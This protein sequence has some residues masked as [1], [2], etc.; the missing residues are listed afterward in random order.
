MILELSK[1]GPDGGVKTVTQGCLRT[2]DTTVLLSSSLRL[3]R[4]TSR[5]NSS[6][7]GK[8]YKVSEQLL[9]I[10][11]TVSTASIYTYAK[12]GQQRSS[13]QRMSIRQVW[14]A[15]SETRWRTGL[16]RRRTDTH[17]YVAITQSIASLTRRDKI[18]WNL[19]VS[20]KSRGI[21][22]DTHVYICLCKRCVCFS[23]DYM[24]WTP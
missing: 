18:D 11:A 16:V 15:Y 2:I 9:N 8:L 22:V 21:Y 10:H 23:I 1:G 6:S 3:D 13:G 24:T 12:I 17:T 7:D 20:T 14:W 19:Y 4:Q 5:S